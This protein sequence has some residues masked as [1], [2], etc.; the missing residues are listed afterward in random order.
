LHRVTVLYEQYFG[1]GSI[2]WSP[3]ARGVL[4]RAQGAKTKRSETDGYVNVL[5]VRTCRIAYSSRSFINIYA[6]AEGDATD[7][8]VER[9]GEIAKK[10]DIS[11]AQLALAWLLSKD[12][13]LSC[14]ISEETR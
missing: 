7:S 14:L 1:V 8:I 5:L 11:M 2:P 10:K 3:L 12:G 6:T 4:T 13:A 9:V